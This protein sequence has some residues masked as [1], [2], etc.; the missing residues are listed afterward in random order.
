MLSPL[1]CNP[2]VD[3]DSNT[4]RSARNPIWRFISTYCP[5]FIFELIELLYNAY[6]FTKLI[7]A[8]RP[9]V[10]YER[11]F[12]FSIASRL[13]ASLRRCPLVYEINDSSFLQQRVRQLVFVTLARAMERWVLSRADLV[14]VVSHSLATMLQQSVGVDPKRILV[15]PNAV[16][17]D[18]VVERTEPAQA[19]KHAGDAVVIGFVGLFVPW[20]GLD[21][22]IDTMAELSRIGIRA[23]LLLVGDGPVRVEVE[24]RAKQVGLRDR[25]T[26]TGT[27]PHSE[28]RAWLSRMD[29]AVLPDSNEY[30]SPMK[31]FEYMAAGRAIVAPDYDPVLEVLE[32]GTNGLTF[33]RRNRAALRNAL[34]QLSEDSE[35]RLRL[36]ENARRHVLRHHT[37][38]INAERLETAL[39]L[40]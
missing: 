33:P 21:L 2:F 23:H 24:W 26:I 37:W 28:V 17:R 38:D 27:V 35:L 19:N 16:E 6:A 29:V 8:R 25:F 15:L 36:G 3:R 13:I 22:L 4:Q 12:I 7:F 9:E 31:I 20:H 10:I 32:H 18:M 40:I 30:G 5:E 14:V 1:G 34:A 39:R 11:Y